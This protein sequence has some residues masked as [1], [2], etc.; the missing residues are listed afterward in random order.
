MTKCPE[1]GYQTEQT[2]AGE[3]PCGLDLTVIQLLDRI[4]EG[5]EEFEKDRRKQAVAE[6]H[7][8]CE[9]SSEAYSKKRRP[10]SVVFSLLALP[11]AIVIWFVILEPFETTVQ[12]IIG[13]VTAF[14]GGGFTAYGIFLMSKLAFAIGY[15][16]YAP[17]SNHLNRSL[18]TAAEKGVSATDVRTMQFFVN[19]LCLLYE[20]VIQAFFHALILLA[21]CIILYF[22]FPNKG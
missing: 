11:L 14:I 4:Y 9:L 17:V 12:K 8:D 20:I 1:C 10:V 2:P 13:P 5:R 18:L 19:L 15:E 7:I 21:V 3:C 22:L 6:L 16:M